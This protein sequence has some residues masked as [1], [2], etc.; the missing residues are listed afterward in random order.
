MQKEGRQTI[1]LGGLLVISLVAV[2]AGVRLYLN[3]A[4]VVKIP[5]GYTPYQYIQTLI[6]ADRNRDNQ[7]N[8][9]DHASVSIRNGE[10]Y[11]VKQPRFGMEVNALERSFTLDNLGTNITQKKDAIF[12]DPT[13]G[14]RYAEEQVLATES[15]LPALVFTADDKAFNSS[16]VVV[17]GATSKNESTQAGGDGT[18]ASGADSGRSI[19]PQVLGTV[20]PYTGSAGFSYPIKVP[21]GPGGYAP[22][23]GISYSSGSVDEGL[24]GGTQIVGLSEEGKEVSEAPYKFPSSYNPS[25]AGYGFSLSGAGSISRDTRDNKTVPTL[26]GEPYHRFI[27]SLPSGVSVQLRYNTT[28]GTW[29]SIP[30]G[31][32]KIER[33]GAPELRK[34]SRFNFALVDPNPWVITTSDGTKYYFGEED[35]GARI[36]ASGKIA[37]P[38][39]NLVIDRTLRGETTPTKQVHHILT[40][41]GG[42]YNE[43]DVADLC[44]GD[45]VNDPCR[46]KISKNKPA[47]LVTK[48]LLKKIET[49][50]GKAINY[51]YEN[52]Q[53]VY[54]QYYKKDWGNNLSVVTTDSYLT[55]IEWNDAKYRVLF[56][57]EPRTDQ[58]GKTQFLSPIRLSGIDVETQKPTVAGYSLMR[59]YKVEYSNGD[60]VMVSGSKNTWNASLV[61]S[62]RE[63]GY[64]GATTTSP[65][66]FQYKQYPFDRG[67]SGST[68]YLDTINNGMGG[69]TTY[70]YQPF[71]GNYQAPDGDAR[72]GLKRVR[73]IEKKVVDKTA[74]N[75]SF[76]ETYNYFN[77]HKAF[78]ER[79]RGEDSS[80]HEFLGHSQVEV[81]T[82][83]FNS[84]KLLAHTLTKFN[85]SIGDA[86][87]TEPSLAKGQVSEQIVYNDLPSGRIEAKKTKT[88]YNYRL[89]TADKSGD[90]VISKDGL[91]VAAKQCSGAD[92]NQ[93]Y[94]VY[95]KS[96]IS[97]VNE[98]LD[99]NFV[100][101]G[102]VSKLTEKPVATRSSASQTLSVDLFG[103]T[104][105]AVS[106]GET[107]TNGKDISTKDN[108]YTFGYYLT[109]NPYWLNNLSY[110]SYSSNKPDCSYTDTACQ[111]GRSNMWYD[112][113][114]GDF[115]KVKIETQRPRI[116]AVTQTQ[117]V[118]DDKT[119]SFAGQEY[120]RLSEKGEDHDTNADNDSADVRLGGVIKTYGPKPNLTTM[121]PDNVAKDIVLLSKT[122]YDS[123][124][125]TMVEETENA[126]G[127]KTK[128]SKFNYELQ[129][130]QRIETQ[131]NVSPARFAVAEATFDPLGRSIT[132]FGPDPKDPTKTLPYPSSVAH[133]FDR[134]DTGLVVRGMKLVSLTADGKP[135]YMTSDSF[136]DGL[137]KVKQA[138]VLSKKI[139][140]DT[141]STS[142]VVVTKRIVTDALYNA[143]GQQSESY[144]VQTA[145]P[146]ELRDNQISSVQP[147]MV[148]IDHKVLSK[149]SY[150]TLNRPVEAVAY[151]VDNNSTLSTKTFFQVNAVKTISPKNVVSI[152]TSDSLGRSID[153]LTIDPTS[154]QHLLTTNAYGAEMI[155][156]PTQ[157]NYSSLK[158]LSGGKTTS[159][160][161]KYDKAGRVIFQDEPS[162][163]TFE[164]AYDILGNK[165]R[166]SRPGRK[167]VEYEYD[168]LGRNTKVKYPNQN[169]G[170]LYKN[171]R[172]MDTDF[173]YD[174]GDNA[175]GKLTSVTSHNGSETYKYDSLGRQTETTKKIRTAP[176]DYT[177]KTE[178]NDISQPLMVEYPNR[179]K[180][181]TV[182]NEEGTAISTS[183]DGKEI[184]M[185]PM[186]D[187]FGNSFQS[188]FVLGTSTYINRTTHD[189]MGRLTQIGVA[190]QTGGQV[191]YQQL[192]YNKLSDLTNVTESTYKDGK[193]AKV[194]YA[195]VYDSY[196]R[197][198]NAQSSLYTTSYSY[199]PFGRM[200]EKNEDQNVSLTFNSSFPF[201]APKSIT[202][203]YTAPNNPVPTN[204]KTPTPQPSTQTQQPT[205]APTVTLTQTPTP[206]RTPTP[207][208]ILPTS[209]LPT[210]EPTPTTKP[211]AKGVQKGPKVAGVNTDGTATYKFEYDQSNGNMLEDDKHCFF[212][213]RLNQMISMKI[214]KDSNQQCKTGAQFKKLIYFYYDASSTLVLQEEYDPKNENKPVKQTYY[215]G[216]YEE[217]YTN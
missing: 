177:S 111:W 175:L 174:N 12:R 78:A 65:I 43:F 67:V 213:N 60:D 75:R 180:L 97:T 57:N 25:Y 63:F 73:V 81:K 205:D 55:K 96:T 188:S 92:I 114:Y 99:S 16:T 17:K 72:G 217:E 120:L 171:S 23:I 30:Q 34:D 109:G 47:L 7:I 123:F 94:F 146:I 181:T 207:T 127:F 214:K 98:P 200:Y 183:L 9:L 147:Q 179:K 28:N 163:G 193:E 56:K 212:Y 74:N 85:Q 136:Y 149:T 209:N 143:L 216:S 140:P 186:I 201:F 164:F 5:P 206:T 80:G 6:A 192:T 157:T 172:T 121:D 14:K 87:C 86:K 18:G 187:K 88:T 83:D 210:E 51:F 53:K 162:L 199:D 197:L 84:D 8:A 71:Q 91:D 134:G 148:T 126:V 168:I 2:F 169:A 10:A 76:K 185:N 194:D 189:T 154:D 26:K 33:H 89:L 64:D 158:D 137:G 132:S 21:A 100:P 102:L 22:S 48:W 118:L 68:I 167:D 13:L 190:K 49:S 19:I 44:K 117:T 198:V 150:D 90:P 61:K 36:E 119:T 45:S 191:Y 122:T 116:G 59:R 70:A 1:L 58:S 204:Y 173:T 112:V 40:K 155:D 141:K 31:F 62:L 32:V 184:A 139:V 108:R 133:Y 107:D 3:A 125:K 29:V 20:S 161:V 27:V 176:H 159:A 128:F 144:E 130:P 42:I 124:F 46:N 52:Y 69:A 39:E 142:P 113:F 110:A 77:S 93:P 79:I 196:S 38:S 151:D 152:A 104:T 208:P 166:E 115:S 95:G 178:Y 182:Y 4:E 50:D 54:G 35:L 138:Q 11:L 145:D 24:Q 82:F 211:Q 160:S 202:K 135:H 101:N 15:K 106:L 195:Y 203:P 41:G 156:K 165:V 170:E 153:G 103:N 129:V 215:I 66:T 131:T 37:T 105:K